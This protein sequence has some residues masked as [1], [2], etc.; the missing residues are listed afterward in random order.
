[1][2]VANAPAA[3]RD[4]LDEL[5]EEA[6]T[7]LEANVEADTPPDRTYVAH[8][9]PVADCDQLTVHLVR[10]QPRLLEDV[11]QGRC[12]VLHQ[13]V[14]EVR[15]WRCWPIGNDKEPVPSA[16]TLGSAARQLAADGWAMW[17]GLT[18]A[19]VE[20]SWPAGVPCKQVKWG[21]LEPLP[22]QGALAGWRLDVTVQL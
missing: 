11:R 1:M 13:A 16:D 22:P 17:K 3:V 10:L 6:I 5:L 12:S 7:A 4:L 9:L 14:M 8:G 21:T 20:G 19:W 18:R 15:L 2:S